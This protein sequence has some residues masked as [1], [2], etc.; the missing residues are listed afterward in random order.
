MM[1]R[2]YPKTGLSLGNAWKRLSLP[3]AV[4]RR[5]TTPPHPSRRGK[6]FIVR[7]T[8]GDGLKD[9]YTSLLTALAQVSPAEIA[10]LV[11]YADHGQ[12]AKRHYIGAPAHQPALP[13]APRALA[14]GSLRLVRE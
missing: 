3:H 10:R 8:T 2:P 5:D 13:K 7:L 14:F 9:T 4:E 11:G 1:S 12:T 6:V